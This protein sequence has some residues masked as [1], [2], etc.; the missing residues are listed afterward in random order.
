MPEAMD[1]NWFQIIVA[2][3]GFRARYGQWPTII[4]LPRDVPDTLA[5]GGLLVK[6]QQ[7]VKLQFDGSPFIAEDDQGRTY[8]VLSDGFL[9]NSDVD[10]RIWL[11]LDSGRVPPREVVSSTPPVPVA[12]PSPD[13]TVFSERAQITEPRKKGKVKPLIEQCIEIQKMNFSFQQKL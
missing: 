5:E 3:N 13:H 11:D 1:K 12:Q 2:I 6:L 8:S 7:K 9:A 10:A 4:R